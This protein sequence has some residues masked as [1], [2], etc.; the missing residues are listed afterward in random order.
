MRAHG[1]G[2][3]LSSEGTPAR[4]LSGVAGWVAA[5]CFG[6]LAMASPHD[7]PG[8]P[9]PLAPQSA[10]G[11]AARVDLATGQAR[12]ADLATSQ[13]RGVDLVTGHARG[14]DLATGQ[15]RRVDLDVIGSSSTSLGDAGH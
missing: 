1:T 12:P 10:T 13:A 6:L 8:E 7:V 2:S 5:W 9:G 4:C 14:V 15:A 11:Q 3:T